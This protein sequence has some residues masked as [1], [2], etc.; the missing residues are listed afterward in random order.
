LDHQPNKVCF[1]SRHALL[2]WHRTREHPGK[3]S[4]LR[5]RQDIRVMDSLP[6]RR[7]QKTII[8]NSQPDITDIVI[9]GR[10]AFFITHTSAVIN[11]FCQQDATDK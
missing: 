11:S 5:Y 3:G 4:Q 6:G 1:R 2:F 7:N 9:S 8:A 10:I